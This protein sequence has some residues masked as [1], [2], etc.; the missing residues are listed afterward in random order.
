M[1]LL[2]SLARACMIAD[3][4]TAWCATSVH[5]FGPMLARCRAQVVPQLIEFYPPHFVHARPVYLNAP[6]L[7]HSLPRYANDPTTYHLPHPCALTISVVLPYCANDTPL[8]GCTKHG[9]RRDL[10]LYFRMMESTRHAPTTRSPTY[11][12]SPTHHMHLSH[13][14]R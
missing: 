3:V 4:Y 8:L 13:N 7:T 12:T 2:T 1:L 6:G 5:F 14:K 10:D 9:I 11:I